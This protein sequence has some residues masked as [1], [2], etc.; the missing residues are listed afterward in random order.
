MAV[1]FILCVL[2]VP[3]QGELIPASKPVESSAGKRVYVFKTTPQGELKA[4]VYLPEGWQPGQKR[5]VI[6][7]FF[8][9]GFTGGSTEQFRTKAEYLA[10]RGM[11]AITPEYRVKSR[12]QTTPDKSIEDAKSAIRWVRMN[13]GALGIDPAR[14]AGSGGSAGGTCAALA[15]WSSAFEAAGEDAAVSAKPDA[16]V[17][18]NPALAMPGGAPS[19][20][21][22]ALLASWK[23]VKSGPPLIQFFGTEDKWLVSGREVAM[24]SAQL[25]NRSE[26]Y[27]AQGLG[28]GFFNDA[29]TAKNGTPGWHDVV[30]LR[31]DLFLTSLG[32]LSG[33]PTVKPD[34]ALALT[35]EPL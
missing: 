5:P 24:Q 28:H 30:L 13:A 15:A 14:V 29:R 16:L 21:P 22:A 25:G 7:M 35:K 6:V 23:L 8:G 26:L 9:G 2:A 4:Q 3:A 32:Y 11:V 18:Y 34:P 20:L 12:H 33:K 17:L 10:G 27:T 31:T 1:A 19:E